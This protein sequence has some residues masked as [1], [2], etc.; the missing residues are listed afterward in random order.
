[1]EARWL[2]MAIAGSLVGWAWSAGDVIHPRR[3]S[4]ARAARPALSARGVASHAAPAGGTRAAAPIA[5]PV[6]GDPQAGYAAGGRHF[7]TWQEERSSAESWA[8][9]LAAG[10]AAADT[11]QV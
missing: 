6:S 4:P 9:E 11:L 5:A 1:M 2:V 8:R 7:F 3:P 10:E